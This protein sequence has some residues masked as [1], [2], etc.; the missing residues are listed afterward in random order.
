MQ[1]QVYD[2]TRSLDGRAAI[3]AGERRSWLAELGED[4]RALLRLGRQMAE[5]LQDAP[6]P[7]RGPQE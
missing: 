2:Q 5:E 1:D 4:Q 6:V 7:G 3:D